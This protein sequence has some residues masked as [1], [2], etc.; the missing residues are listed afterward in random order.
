MVMSITFCLFYIEKLLIG[1]CL[2]EAN[3]LLT[4]EKDFSISVM[5]VSRTSVMGY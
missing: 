5:Y 4:N 3:E 2:C 1:A